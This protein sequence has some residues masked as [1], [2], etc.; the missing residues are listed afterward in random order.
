MRSWIGRLRRG[1]WGS[2][3]GSVR[4]GRGGWGMYMFVRGG[5]MAGGFMASSDLD[6]WYNM[7][8]LASA[9][10]KKDILLLKD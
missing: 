3:G 6:Q 2:W 5:Y 7:H 8:G 10:E 1:W 9:S 4:G